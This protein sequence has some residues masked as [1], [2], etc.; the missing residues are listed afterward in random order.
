MHPVIIR[1]GHCPI[2]R[3]IQ[4]ILQP[5]PCSP[6][7]GLAAGTYNETISILGTSGAAANV[8]AQFSVTAA[9]NGGDDGGSHGGGGTVTTPADTSD[10]P[11]RF[12]GQS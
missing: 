9:D 6:K 2:Q 4:E 3:L 1:L 11:I 5:L 12:N 8:S 7:T 10:T